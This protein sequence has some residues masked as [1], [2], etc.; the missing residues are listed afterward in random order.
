MAENYKNQLKSLLKNL[1]QFDS[2]DLDFGIYRIMNKKRTE[3][4]RFIE[5]DLIDVV[6]AEFSEYSNSKHENFEEEVEAIKSEIWDKLGEDAFDENEKVKP[7]FVTTPFAK[8]LVGKYEKACANMKDSG[9][10][11]QH[12]AEIFSHIFQFFSRYY[13]NGDFMSMRRYSQKE[14]Y[15]IPYNGEE[16]M[17]HWA[18]K[19]QYYIKT[20]VNFKNYSFKVGEYAVE[21]LIKEAEAT[22]NNNKA[23]KRFFVLSSSDNSLDYNDSKKK[24]TIFFEYRGLTQEEETKYG[25]TNVQENILTKLNEEIISRVSDPGLKTALDKFVN[26]STKRKVLEKHLGVYTKKNTTD[27][28]IHK[29]LKNF[30]S[31]EL[32]FYIKN[33]VFHLDDLGTENEVTVEQYV[34]RAKVMKNICLKVIDLLAQIEDFQKM[35]FEKKKFVVKT[36]YC[37]TLD[38]VPDELYSEIVQNEDQ[39]NEWSELNYIGEKKQSNLT[40]FGNED[41]NESYLREHLYLVIDTKFFKYEF[42]DRLLASFDDIDEAT[43]GLMINSE[44]WQALNLMKEKYAEKVKCIYIDPPYNTG[45]DEFIYKDAYQHSSWLTMMQ[46][47]L[48]SSKELLDESGVIYS[49]IDDIESPNLRLLMDNVFNKNNFISQLVWKKKA[50][51][52]SD[53]RYYAADHEYMVLFSKDET[54]QEKYF[55][56]LTGT[57]KSE[58]K[59]NDEN[60]EKFGPYKRKNLYQTGIDT[61]RPNLRYPIKCP[62]GI[63]IYPPTIWRWEQKRFLK[64]L[65]EGKI[66]FIKNRNDEWQIFTKM[67]LYDENGNEYRIKPRSILLNIALTRNGNTE[68][69]NLFNKTVFDYPKPTDLIKYIVAINSSKSDIILDFFSGSGTTGHAVLNLNKEDNGK[70]KYILVEMG[71]YFESVTKPRIQKVMYSDK[72]KGGKPLSDEGISHIFKYQSLEQYEDTLNNIEFTESGSVQRTLMDMDGYFLRYMLDFETKDKSPC[73]LN[74]EK[75]NKPFDYTLKIANGN[76]LKEEK[77]DLVETFNYLLGIHVKNIRTFDNNGTYYK[78]VVGKKEEDTILIIWRDCENLDLKEDKT[79]IEEKII[80]EFKPSK[81]YINAD[82]YVERALPIEPEFKK[83]MVV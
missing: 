30:L 35:L 15:A 32:D 18:N 39:L 81:T 63:E 61:D 66:D 12:E 73:R 42:K 52:G 21:F 59:Y 26:E 83:L 46:D 23:D 43:G 76:E 44:N 13:D 50:G 80:A 49:S 34:T 69:K 54:K 60:F 68:L 77:V 75:L 51:G 47:R 5:K 55:T 40:S 2:A 67:Y 19:D 10:S 17:L 62:D 33:E 82:F 22:A 1:F 28:F 57:L 20:G 56:G 38:N 78:V 37:V 14:K 65:D 3:I 24:L 7:I 64:E 16:V 72:W 11:D 36:D 45:S 31:Q 6:N 9:M 70:R 4:E 53:A 48:L 74:I 8:E 27:Y 71:E 29:D 41:I 25:K 79:F 58:Y